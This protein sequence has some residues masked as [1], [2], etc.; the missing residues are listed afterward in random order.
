MWTGKWSGEHDCERLGF[1]V[2]GDKS[3]P[4]LIGCSLTMCGTPMRNGGKSN[5]DRQAEAAS[6]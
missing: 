3:F 5:N 6:A 2:N 4:D 1:Y